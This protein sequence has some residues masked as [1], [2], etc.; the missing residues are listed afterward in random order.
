[1]ESKFAELK[2]NVFIAARDGKVLTLYAMLCD[3]SLSAVEVNEILQ[4]QTEEDSQKT[5][6]FIIANRNGHD[7]VVKLLLHHFDTDI[8]QVGT[9]KFDG[10]IIEGATALWCAAAAGHLDVV[11]VLINVGHADVNHTTYS[12]STPLRAACFDGR[13]DIVKYLIEHKADLHISNKYNNTCLMISCYRGHRRVVQ[14][15]LEQGADPN[16]K[17]NCGATAL[18]FSSERGHLSITK[19]LVEYGAAMLLNDQGMSPLHIAAESS[20]AA[21]VEYFC[22]MSSVSR[23]EGIEA[24][25]LLGASFAND[26]DNYDLDRAYHYMWLAMQKRYMENEKGG[27]LLKTVMTPIEAYDYRL[28]AQT[29]AQLEQMRDDSDAIHM[30]ALI[31]RERI[32]SESNAEIPHP[33]IFRG[34]VFAD[35]A[36]FD[37]CT[38]LWM[39]ALVLRQRNSRSI[40]KDLLRFAQV[41][42]QMLHIGV[43]LDSRLPRKVFEHS[44]MELKRDKRKCDDASVSDKP[45][46]CEAI[47]S[48]IYT[49]LY[50]LVI[51]TKLKYSKDEEHELCKLIYRFVRLDLISSKTGYSPLHLVLDENTYV[52]DFHVVDVVTFPCGAAAK[53]LVECGADVNAVDMKGNTPLHNIV[54]YTKPI[55]D[56]LTLHSVIMLLIDNGCHMDVCNKDQETPL[57]VSATGVAEIILRTQGK[58]SLKCIAARAVKKQGLVYQGNIPASL[59]DFV[60]LH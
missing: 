12:N 42:S 49:A 18:H 37:R 53:L 36:R 45:A 46:L 59:E 19:D 20:H 4:A 9:V 44:I 22:S 2:K 10:Y 57:D 17:A 14:Y 29:V 54:K 51:L 35:T 25:E 13:L 43:Y 21:I 28:E 33:I 16:A 32:L 23:L 52:D 48:N 38:A 39:R 40:A 3:L 26:K 7:K 60:A 34:A 47:D 8:E 58:I 27:I 31:I 6:P 5:T 30:E 24:L 50:L 56:F 15:L 41:F 11:K 55:S 1:M